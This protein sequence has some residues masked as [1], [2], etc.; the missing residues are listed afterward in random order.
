MIATLTPTN[1]RFTLETLA[2]NCAD[3]TRFEYWCEAYSFR[4]KDGGM[5]CDNALDDLDGAVWTVDGERRD[6]EL[7]GNYIDPVFLELRSIFAQVVR[8]LRH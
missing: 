8:E 4:V 1:D 7:P 3:R 5:T 6:V 2:K